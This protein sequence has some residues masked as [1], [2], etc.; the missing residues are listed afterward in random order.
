MP[1][2]LS[3]LS[4][5][6]DGWFQPSI[7]LDRVL[8]AVAVLFGLLTIFSSV[9]AGSYTT[10]ATSLREIAFFQDLIFARQATSDSSTRVLHAEIDRIQ[11]EHRRP[12]PKTSQISSVSTSALHL[13]A[14]SSLRL[15]SRQHRLRS[16]PRSPCPRDAFAA[17]AEVRAV[18]AARVPPGNLRVLFGGGAM[19]LRARRAHAAA[20]NMVP[21]T[22]VLLPR[23]RI[24]RRTALNVLLLTAATAVK[25]TA[26]S[27][28][29][30]AASDSVPVGL[31]DMP[32]G[33][34]D[35]QAG[36]DIMPAGSESVPAGCADLPHGIE[37]VPAGAVQKQC[38]SSISRSTAAAA[39]HTAGGSSSVAAKPNGS[40]DTNKTAVGNEECPEAANLAGGRN[41]GEV[42]PGGSSIASLELVTAGMTDCLTLCLTDRL[43]VGLTAQ[44]QQQQTLTVRPAT[45]APETSLLMSS[46]PV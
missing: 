13:P 31:K 28:G 2:V 36:N 26:G 6:G 37:N 44:Q 25:L 42:A 35:M 7:R 9:T 43:T 22:S 34:A 33:R 15:L 27:E 5:S 18:A 40:S 10:W 1:V 11:A 46:L 24:S 23:S 20:R 29:V 4:D 19:L 38:T 14:F 17:A 41:G 12:D 21:P 39:T 16:R 32:A 8:G 3:S 30:P 45:C